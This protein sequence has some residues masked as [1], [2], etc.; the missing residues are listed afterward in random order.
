[1][2]RRPRLYLPDQPQ[3]VV[4][5]G[6][7]RDPIFACHDDFRFFYKCLCEAA[8]RHQSSI[9]AW[10][11]MHNHIHLLVTPADAES[12]PRTMQSVGRRYAQY[13]NRRYHR[14]GSLWEGRYKVG[15]VD[16]EDYLL[17]C[18][19]YIELNPVRAG[20][21]SKPEDYP[22]SSYQA[23]ALGKKDALVTPHELY[24]NYVDKGP[25][26]CGRGD[27]LEPR[28]V[29]LASKPKAPVD[30]NSGPAGLM[31]YRSLFDEV[32]TRKELTDIRRGTEKG[33]GIGRAEFLLKVAKL[34]SS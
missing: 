27:S 18:Y 17:A 2:P 23:N 32:L 34:V 9:H 28:A 14:S 5:R 26:S 1:M 22:Y 20:I 29:M 15:L 24:L 8:I 11:F 6:H 4:V 19:R 13:F 12:L 10:V 31:Y 16:T 25:E 7:N 21:V 30:S 33:L 3:H